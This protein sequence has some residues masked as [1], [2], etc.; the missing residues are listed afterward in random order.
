[1]VK[2][3]NNVIYFS[4]M[5]VVSA[6]ENGE[7]FSEI[8]IPINSCT[9]R[10]RIGIVLALVLDFHG[11]PQTN[12][13]NMTGPQASHTRYFLTAFSSKLMEK[14]LSKIPDPLSC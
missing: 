10:G 8:I 6:C 1:M 3:S 5:L 11:I 14:D 9:F 4:N 7:I 2:V 13:L 12:I